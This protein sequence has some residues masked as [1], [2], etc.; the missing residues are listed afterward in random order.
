MKVKRLLKLA[1][2]LATVPRR[3]FNIGT[4]VEENTCGTTACALGH[5]G[6]MPSFRKAGLRSEPDEFGGD[7]FFEGQRSEEA[8]AAFFGLTYEE[9]SY[10]FMPWNYAATKRG[11]KS[12]AQR[13]R[14]MVKNGG[15][16]KK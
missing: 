13:I 6:L 14:T 16:K 1:D 8:G 12:V 10:L 3:R 5:A 15:I 7:V 11:P 2:Y 9:A 4:W